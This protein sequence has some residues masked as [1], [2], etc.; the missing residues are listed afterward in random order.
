MA[1]EIPLLPL[2][3]VL[4]PGMMLPLHIFE[5]QYKLM[6]NRCLEGDRSFGVVSIRGADREGV[7]VPHSV[8]T[9][10]AIAKVEKLQDGEMNIV[11]V[12]ERRFRL[13]EMLRREPYPTGL[14]EY[15]A[16]DQPMASALTD[17]S[18]TAIR[19]FR[20][21][22]ELLFAAAGRDAPRIKVPAEPE[23]LS[24]LIAANMRVSL[25]QKQ[26]LLEAE[27]ARERL[28]MEIQ[29]LRIENDTLKAI[30]ETAGPLP[31][32]PDAPDE[33]DD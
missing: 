12:G 16:P 29:A 24:Y 18:D 1:E 14:V 20:R 3:V 28:E 4:F 5:E 26:L 31:Q 13:I 8:G 19:L 11:T 30:L 7:V 33:D 6:V 21:H 27:S 15:L 2:H 25:E 10:A 23:P 32:P 9:V 17:V 22:T